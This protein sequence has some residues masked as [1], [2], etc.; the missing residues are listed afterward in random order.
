MAVW[1][2]GRYFYVIKV[3]MRIFSAF[4][5]QVRNYGDIMSDPPSLSNDNPAPCHKEVPR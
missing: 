2:R 3:L 4:S 1:V 5:L